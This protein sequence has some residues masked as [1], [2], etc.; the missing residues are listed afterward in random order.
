MGSNKLFENIAAIS[1]VVNE[2]GDLGPEPQ[3]EVKPEITPELVE[4]IYNAIGDDSINKEQFGMGLQVELEHYDSVM[5]DMN[6]VA[7]IV[8][9]H[10]REIPNYYDYL[11]EMEAKAK[12]DMANTESPV[13]ETPVVEETPSEPV[14]ATDEGKIP[15]NPAEYTEKDIQTLFEGLPTGTVKIGRAH[16]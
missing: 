11:G 9:D 5:K 4:E 14:N 7:S 3:V 12:E 10:L 16:V 6:T 1:K 13:E 15:A 8:I 2:D